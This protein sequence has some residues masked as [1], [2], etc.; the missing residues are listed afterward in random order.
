MSAAAVTARTW[1]RT[2]IHIDAVTAL[3]GER[4]AHWEGDES[5]RVILQEADICDRLH[6]H[7]VVGARQMA[8]EYQTFAEGFARRDLRYRPPVEGTSAPEV[9]RHLVK[10]EC[11]LGALEALV[12][13]VLGIELKLPTTTERGAT[14]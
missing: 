5:T 7:V 6:D 11:H 3:L 10:Y 14:R 4:A 12:R 9:T 13:A 2:T 8:R 1:E